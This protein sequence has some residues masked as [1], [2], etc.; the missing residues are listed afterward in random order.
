M[1]AYLFLAMWLA[2]LVYWWR[3]AGSDGLNELRE[4]GPSRLVRLLAILGALALL[5][6]PSVPLPWFDRRFLPPGMACV[7]V[8]LAVTAGGLLFAAW[9]SYH[10]GN[11]WSQAVTIKQ[12]H[13]LVTSGPHAIVR[14]PIYTGLLFGF[15]GMAVALGELRGVLAVG[16]V[17]AV[18]WA[19][20]RLEEKW[21]RGHFGESYDAYSQRVKVL[22]PYLI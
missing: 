1:Y 12:G 18:L 17:F 9:A 7:W 16:L 22:L 20:L 14:H 19:K 15:I 6:L 3:M 2:L 10:L 4:S 21:I 13:E 5:C 8:G 11:N